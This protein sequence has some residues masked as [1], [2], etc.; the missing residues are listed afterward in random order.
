MVEKIRV[1]EKMLGRKKNYN[2]KRKK[3]IQY[4]RKS[5]VAKKNIK[6]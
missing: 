1:I 6:R 4:V 5:I 3:N 2:P